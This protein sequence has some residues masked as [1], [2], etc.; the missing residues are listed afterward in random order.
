MFGS[1]GLPRGNV[2]VQGV[3]HEGDK[4]IRSGDVL[5]HGNV[6]VR[7]VSHEGDKVIRSG[8]VCV[9]LDDDEDVP[10]LTGGDF[11]ICKS[12]LKT[13]PVVSKSNPAL[14]G[15]LGVL[16]NHDFTI[17]SDPTARLLPTISELRVEHD[18]TSALA[19]HRFLDQMLKSLTCIVTDP[20]DRTSALLEGSLPPVGALLAK[21]FQLYAAM[22]WPSVQDEHCRHNPI[23]MAL[24]AYVG[25][26][27]YPLGYSPSAI[28]DMFKNIHFLP[29]GD[30]GL[31]ALDSQGASLPWSRCLGGNFG[32]VEHTRVEAGALDV[33][34][35]TRMRQL[36]NEGYDKRSA[37]VLVVSR[38]V[39]HAFH[40]PQANTPGGTKSKGW[41]RPDGM[42]T[43]DHEMMNTIYDLASRF[44]NPPIVI[45]PPKGDYYG[46]EG[47]YGPV[48][49]NKW[50]ALVDEQF[51]L[52]AGKHAYYT[53]T[54]K[55]L[56]DSLRPEEWAE[57]KEHLLIKENSATPTKIRVLL[58][59][60]GTELFNGSPCGGP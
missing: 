10:L 24:R 23:N 33:N 22:G 40:R 41:Q 8:D 38:F 46:Y 34:I 48:V 13:S 37:V 44:Q 17:V 56:Y 45:L 53:V 51:I 1:G 12:D 32:S 31:I 55:S 57:D 28:D 47:R 3:S 19:W 42:T 18:P 39:N 20:F 2:P 27:V 16:F 52:S 25:T 36:I 49:A 43:N 58:K 54:P 59:S 50:Q 60:C 7:G 5:P 11:D 26:P 35:A 9:N 4:V 29:V 14:S 30:S 21:A 6:P 15:S